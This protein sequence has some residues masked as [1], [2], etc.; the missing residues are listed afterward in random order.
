MFFINVEHGVN[1]VRELWI[2]DYYTYSN[3]LYD[4]IIYN[5]LGRDGYGSTFL[6]LLNLHN[7][8]LYKTI[9]LVSLS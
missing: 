6:F 1:F 5:S 9:V 3:L 7:F 4:T 2:R 8:Q